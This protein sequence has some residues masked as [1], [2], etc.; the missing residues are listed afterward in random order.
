[1]RTS[2]SAALVLLGAWTLLVLVVLLNSA[3][4]LA[5]D[6]KPELY[7]APW[8]MT[9]FFADPWQES[10]QLGWPSF[11]V[12]LVPVPAASAGLQV[13]GLSPLMSMRVLRILLYTAGA[14]GMVRL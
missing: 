10:P 4:S 1:M 12:G 2:R 11:N 14:W 7:L 5:V 13:L 3:G 9:T 6:I 8:R